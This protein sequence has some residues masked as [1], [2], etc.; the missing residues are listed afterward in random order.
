M[1]ALK[2]HLLKAIHCYQKREGVL[3]VEGGINKK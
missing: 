1:M 3:Q 2:S